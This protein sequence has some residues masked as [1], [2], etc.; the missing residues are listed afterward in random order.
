MEW[1]YVDGENDIEASSL[2]ASIKDLSLN[3]LSSYYN[4][5]LSGGEL[6]S[7]LPIGS[8]VAELKNNLTSLCVRMNEL[9]LNLLK[10][11]MQEEVIPIIMGIGEDL[12]FYPN[13]T[14][15]DNHFKN[16]SYYYN[17]EDEK[18]LLGKISTREGVASYFRVYASLNEDK[19]HSRERVIYMEHELYF[20]NKV[21]KV[22]IG[23]MEVRRMETYRAK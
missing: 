12:H 10:K 20:Y 1:L 14:I 8:N 9:A 2:E 23:G 18:F 16:Y 21:R 6:K 4:R 5:H 17:N 15:N 3:D 7:V 19:E 13:I 22:M 11:N